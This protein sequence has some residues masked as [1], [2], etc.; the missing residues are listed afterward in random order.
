MLRLNAIVGLSADREIAA[1]LHLLDHEGRIEFILLDTVEIAR[2]RI[3]VTTD[4]GTECRIELPR[5]QRLVDGAVLLLE[6]KRALVVKAEPE[7]W[8]IFDAADA[9][10][11]LEL[12]YCA[13]N[14]HWPVRFLGNRLYVIGEL[15]SGY[16]LDRLQHILHRGTVK[17]LGETK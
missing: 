5:T 8:L 10:A 6:D 16:V 17:F 1:Q 13:G 12:G 9:A 2:R 3:S 11:G 15:G 14:M 7:R 4:R